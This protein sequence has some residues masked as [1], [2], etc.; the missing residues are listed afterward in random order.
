MSAILDMFFFFR[1]NCPG[2]RAKAL[3]VILPIVESVVKVAS[4][5]YCL[6]GRIYK[7][8]FMSSAFTDAH[9]RDQACYW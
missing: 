3:A 9:S 8:T 5:V 7:D 6:C 4:D 1:R 2:D